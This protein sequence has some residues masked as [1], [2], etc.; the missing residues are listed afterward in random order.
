ML[1]EDW[2]TMLNLQTIVLFYCN[3]PAVLQYI[4]RTQVPGRKAQYK[5]VNC[6]YVL[7]PPVFPTSVYVV[8]ACGVYHHRIVLGV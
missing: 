7:G 3:L 4:H 6:T 1:P 5:V 2:D 8:A